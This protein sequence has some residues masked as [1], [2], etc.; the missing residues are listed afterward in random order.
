[1]LISDAGR[2][3]PGDVVGQPTSVREE[4]AGEIALR[5][6]VPPVLIPLCCRLPFSSDNPYVP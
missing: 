6:I 3:Q 5:T 1:M 2:W 4:I